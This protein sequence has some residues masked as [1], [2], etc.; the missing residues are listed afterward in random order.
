[1]T[2]LENLCA[3]PAVARMVDGTSLVPRC[4][5][6]LLVY[7]QLIQFRQPAAPRLPRFPPWLLI[8]N[9]TGPQEI[10]HGATLRSMRT[11][12]H[13]LLILQVYYL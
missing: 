4:P 13:H 9:Q 5:S 3:W 12:W 1:H 6:N 10:S 11:G 8:R 2:H 7:T